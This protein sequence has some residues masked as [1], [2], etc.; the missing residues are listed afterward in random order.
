MR[1]ALVPA[2]AFA[3][4]QL[5]FMLAFDRA[6][7]AQLAQTGHAYLHSLV[8]WLV[9]LLGVAVGVFLW[10]LGRALAGQR[11][12]PRYTLSLAALWLLCTVCLVA[13]YAT[14]ELL[15][16]MLAGGHA[17]GWAGV[18]GY[19]GWWSLPAAA[20]VGL[21]L[22]AC[23]HGARWAL[24]QVARRRSDTRAVRPRRTTPRRPRDIVVPRPL[25][26]ANG[27]SGRGPPR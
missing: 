21:V 16:G 3:V 22:A 12:A 23:L 24:D 26:L 1:A 7:G 9:A 6:S 5:R 19:G 17:A 2:A 14:Q 11:S 15:E 10:G 8:P 25:P 20:A 27:W 18:F 4:H 13:I